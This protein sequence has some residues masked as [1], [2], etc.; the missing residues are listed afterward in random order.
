MKRLL[1]EKAKRSPRHIIVRMMSSP[2]EGLAPNDWQYG[3]MLGPAPPVLVVR[4]D[5]IEFEIGDW[6]VLDDF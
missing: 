3:G 5:S 6:K 2:S 4:N 1:T